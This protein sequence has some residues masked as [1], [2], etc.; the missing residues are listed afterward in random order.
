[1]FP[2]VPLTARMLIGPLITVWSGIGRTFGAAGRSTATASAFR[3]ITTSAPARTRARSDGKS[4]AASA[5][6]TRI[7]GLLIS[8]DCSSLR[9]RTPG[10]A[11]PAL[12]FPRAWPADSV[13]AFRPLMC[14]RD[15]SKRPARAG[16]R[17]WSQRNRI[18]ISPRKH[19][20][21]PSLDANE[22]FSPTS[23]H[24][25]ANTAENRE[26]PETREQDDSTTY[27]TRRSLQNLHPPGQIRAARPNKQ[28]VD[29]AVAALG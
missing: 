25:R 19:R 2:I 18:A 14:N 10:Q 12:A 4:F 17:R 8:F 11:A 1:M 20:D 5:S 16:T 27:R 3:P 13:R 9:E 7:A 23:V 29:E 15:A 21:G 28:A 24:E 22:N 6:D 26:L